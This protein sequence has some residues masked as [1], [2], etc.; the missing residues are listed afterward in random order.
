[1]TFYVEGVSRTLT[2]ELI[3]HRFLAFSEVSQR[4]IGMEDSYTVVPPAVRGDLPIEYDLEEHHR[5][6][7]E[8]Y[9]KLVGSLTSAGKTRKE[10]R[11]AARSVLPGGTETKIIVTGNIRAWIDF[12][13]QRWTAGADE[14]I[15]ELA[16]QILMH[17]RDF[18]PNS[19]Q[20]IPDT[21][22]GM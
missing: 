20:H 16:G 11:Q 21:P 6:S 7:V 9:D 19:I 17:L 18:C 2:H 12:I 4:Y 15:R 13:Q 22:Y 10:A 14:E 1:M 5:K 8:L 3:R